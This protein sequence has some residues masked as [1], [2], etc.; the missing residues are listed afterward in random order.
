MAMFEAKV[1]SIAASH[2]RLSVIDYLFKHATVSLKVR[3]LPYT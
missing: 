3:N 2:E 1:R